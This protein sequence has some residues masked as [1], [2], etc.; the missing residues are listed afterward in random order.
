MSNTKINEH[1]NL[2]KQPI[3]HNKTEFHQTLTHPGKHIFSV[4][5]FFL[6]FSP[7]KVVSVSSPKGT[8]S[9][10]SFMKENHRFFLMQPY[11]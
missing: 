1:H 3:L 6:R 8:I 4:S 9:R 5:F 10:D 11:A 2:T 7:V